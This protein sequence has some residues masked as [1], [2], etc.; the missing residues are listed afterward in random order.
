MLNIRLLLMISI[1]NSFNKYLI[2]QRDIRFEPNISFTFFKILYI[3]SR[4]YFL[5]V[6]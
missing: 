3:I 4:N 1:E 6:I 2:K 5:N